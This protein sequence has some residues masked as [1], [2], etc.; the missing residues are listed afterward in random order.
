MQRRVLVSFFLAG[1]AVA[2]AQPGQKVFTA[3]GKEYHVQPLTPGKWVCVGGQFT[4]DV[5]GAPPC[6]PGTKSIIIHDVSNRLEY[7]DVTGSGA[8][9]LDGWNVTHVTGNLDGNYNGKLWCTFEWTVPA[10]NGKWVGTCSVTTDQGGSVNRAEALGRGGKL[11]GLKLEFY[12]IDDP[13][14]QGYSIFVAA[15]TDFGKAEQ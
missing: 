10:M 7:Q 13:S 8:P 2:Y 14:G 5:P 3:T 9:M 1:L 15:I 11:E 4:G 12:A 6:S